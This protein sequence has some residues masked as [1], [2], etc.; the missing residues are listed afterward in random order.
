MEKAVREK[1]TRETANNI[2]VIFFMSELI[3]ICSEGN[4]F[5]PKALSRQD[6]NTKV[7]GTRFR[8]QGSRFKVQRFKGLFSISNRAAPPL[9]LHSPDKM[10]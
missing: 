1:K 2:N 4:K 7:S 9:R 5:C 3:L 6:M 8:V 10:A